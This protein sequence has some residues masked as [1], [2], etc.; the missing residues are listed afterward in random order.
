MSTNVDLPTRFEV[1]LEFVQSLANIQYVTYL[2]T[3]K[4]ISSNFLNKNKQNADKKNTKGNIQVWKDPKFK[5]YLKYLE[6]WCYPPY[7]QCIVYPNALFVLKLINGFMEK[8]TINEDGLLE[9][10]EDLPRI[11]QLQGGQL[12]NEM[13]EK[14][15]S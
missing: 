6:Y 12:M 4:T 8:A 10:I 14:W 2:F 5:N 9:G 15:E 11:L 7:S 3:Q 1:E 13:V